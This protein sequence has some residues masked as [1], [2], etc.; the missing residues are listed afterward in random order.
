[1]NTQPLQGGDTS[2]SDE[3]EELVFRTH[4]TAIEDAFDIEDD[5]DEVEEDEYNNQ[6]EE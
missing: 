6:Y 3:N 4:G 5:C 2:S 1:M